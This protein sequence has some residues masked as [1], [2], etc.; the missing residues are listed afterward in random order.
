MDRR[1]PSADRDGTVLVP[2]EIYGDDQIARWD[3]D[4]A[5]D[6]DERQR[7]ADALPAKHPHSARCRAELT[8]SAPPAAT[9]TH[10]TE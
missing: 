9:A 2:D 1:K 3:A 8:S 5:L 7:I 6:D 4:D 10:S